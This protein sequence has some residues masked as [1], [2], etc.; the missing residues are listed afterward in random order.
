MINIEYY[1]KM[2]RDNPERTRTRL[3]Q[4]VDMGMIETGT[5]SFG[6]K[7]VM[8]GLYIERVWHHTDEQWDDYIKWVHELMVKHI[9]HWEEEKKKC[10]ESLVYFAEKYLYIRLPDGSAVRPSKRMLKELEMLEKLWKADKYY[11]INFFA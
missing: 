9:N 8:S 3:Q 6:I 4:I 2:D 7:H 1:V 5:A 10:E 11:K